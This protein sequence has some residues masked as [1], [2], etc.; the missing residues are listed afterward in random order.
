MWTHNVSYSTWVLELLRHGSKGGHLLLLRGMD[1]HDSG[2]QDAQQA[3][4]LPVN[5]QPLIQEV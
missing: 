1:D 5:I 2:T 4:H 3:T